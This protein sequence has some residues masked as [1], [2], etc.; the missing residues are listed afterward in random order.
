MVKYKLIG[1]T[2]IIKKN[3]GEVIYKLNFAFEDEKTEGLNVV[4]EWSKNLPTAQIG[5]YYNLYY[6]RNGFL[7]KL[8]EVTV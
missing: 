8:E 7:E 2:T 6:N 1:V 5:K 4:F 3:T